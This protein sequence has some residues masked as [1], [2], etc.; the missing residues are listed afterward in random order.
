MLI[1]LIKCESLT[2]K[3]L[4]SILHREAFKQ[5]TMLHSKIKEKSHFITFRISWCPEGYTLCASG[6]KQTLSLLWSPF[7]QF[8]P[9]YH[10]KSFAFFYYWPRRLMRAVELSRWPPNTRK[11]RKIVCVFLLQSLTCNHLPALKA[12][13]WNSITLIWWTIDSYPMAIHCC[14][15]CFKK[16]KS[17]MVK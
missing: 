7:T 3:G 16:K 8:L 10:L 15:L 17:H 9:F 14:F 4:S 5:R 6:E 12:R 13:L 1:L 11:D 2:F